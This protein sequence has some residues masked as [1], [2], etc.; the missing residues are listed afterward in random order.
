[1]L[2]VKN[3]C[4]RYN[5]GDSAP[6]LSDVSFSLAKG[7]RI[8]LT[9][10]NGAGKSTLLSALVGILLPEQGSVIFDGLELR[11]GGGSLRDT[12]DAFRRRI[13]FVMQNPDDQLFTPTVYDD[14]AFGLRSQDAPEEEVGKKV[15]GVMNALGIA[16]LKDRL[17]HRLS[18]G[19]KRLATLAG[20]L[21]M[22][23][24]LLL[25]DEPAT[26]LDPPGRERLIAILAGLDQSMIIATHDLGMAE[27]LCNRILRLDRGRI[28]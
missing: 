12:V 9:G 21:V 25:L 3:L 4:V 26:F 7:E 22:E 28:V 16:A 14:I 1:M 15:D 8:A 19:E 27:C 20:V 2:E 23:P 5:A 11:S 6:A 13:G 24:D 18:G 10:N 17:T